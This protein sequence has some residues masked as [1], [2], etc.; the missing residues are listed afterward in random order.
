VRLRE[1]GVGTDAL[2]ALDEVI[3]TTMAD[4]NRVF[5]EP[6]PDGLLLDVYPRGCDSR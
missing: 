4:A 3:A 6:L 1:A 5:G 2:Q